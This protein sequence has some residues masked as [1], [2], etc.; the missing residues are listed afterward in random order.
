M[1]A[2][3]D[4]AGPERAPLVEFAT[5]FLTANGDA[6]ELK[7]D[8]LPGYFGAQVANDSLVPKDDYRKG[9]THLQDWLVRTT[10]AK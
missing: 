3:V 7:T 8:P 5:R 6:R 4:L 10:A 9:A 1:N 2:T